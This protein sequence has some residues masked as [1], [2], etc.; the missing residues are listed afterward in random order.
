MFLVFLVVAC[1]ACAVPGVLLTVGFIRL[2]E[3]VGRRFE[4]CRPWATA[5]LADTERRL[6]EGL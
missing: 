1:T 4:L 3:R 2:H 6:R 5:E